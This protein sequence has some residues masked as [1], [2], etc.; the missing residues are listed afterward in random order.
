M[1][2]KRIVIT[3]VGIL[4]PIGIG[5]KE[6]WKNLFAGKS[7]I[8][9]ITVF[10]T[11]RLKVKVAGEITGF[12]P[13]KILEEKRLIDL[14]RA[15]LL[16]LSA[17]KLAIEDSELEITE[18]NTY[19]TGVA[20]GTTFGSVNSV[21][22][23]DREALTEGPRYANPSVFPSTVGNSPASRISIRYKI[24]GFNSTISTGISAGLDA[25]EYSS[26]FLQLNR[27]KQ[28]L[29]GSVEDLSNQVFM[30]LYKLD[31]LSGLHGSE[32]CSCP[33]DKKRDGV[34]FAEGATV[35]VVQEENSVKDKTKIYGQVSGI[36]S[37]F[38]PARFYRYNPKGTGMK[39]AMKA[40]LK[41]AGLEPEEIDCIYANANSTRGG[42]AIEAMA[43]KDVFG[44]YANTIPVTAVKS[45]VGETYS[46]SGPLAI[47][48][49]LGAIKKGNISP[50]LNYKNKDKNCDLNF[51]IE[52][53]KQKKINHV[54]VNTFGPNGKNTSVIISK[55]GL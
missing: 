1:D 35:F 40:A 34:V 2:K 12:D 48:A 15:T 9:P 31:Y 55:H 52:K 17:A 16:L 13:H 27:A 37:A 53:S 41:D 23:Y 6:F 8:K 49:A 4:S 39:K 45:I 29:V 21:S 18:K 38:D 32:P 50:I 20:I 42:D 22:K 44:D 54:I 51:V 30:G 5:V 14:D 33:F 3:G 36:G 47:A 25:L 11:D 46:N 10:D 26:D 24:K 7:G 19:K 43:I 28:I